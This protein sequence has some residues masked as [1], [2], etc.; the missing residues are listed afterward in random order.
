MNRHIG[1]TNKLSNLLEDLKEI[2]EI[3]ENLKDENE[4]TDSQA[5]Y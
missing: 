4:H 1:I 2:A 3:I 5:D